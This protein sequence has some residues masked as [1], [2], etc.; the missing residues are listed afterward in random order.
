MAT[1]AEAAIADCPQLTEK[2]MH[3][4]HQVQYAKRN[5][6]FDAETMRIA[7]RLKSINHQYPFIQ[8]KS[9][10]ETHSHVCRENL[11]RSKDFV[12]N[13]GTRNTVVGSNE[14]LPG[15]IKKTFHN[16][17]KD[18][19]FRTGTATKVFIFTALCGAAGTGIYEATK[20]LKKP[21]STSNGTK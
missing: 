5:V 17:M 8:Q 2:F 9:I 14:I 7:N 1:V 10:Y 12:E 21:S 4:L 3:N 6:I 19:F 20:D 11:S 15:V 18:L 16:P 13:P